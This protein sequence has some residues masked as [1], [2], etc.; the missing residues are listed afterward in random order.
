MTEPAELADGP[1]RLGGFELVSK[2]AEGGMGAVYRA[3]QLSLD[4]TV[5]VK[6]LPER[7]A[8]NQQFVA[9]FLREARLAARFSHPNVVG[10]VDA[11]E[12]D[13]VHYFA[14]EY[15]E[16]ESLGDLLK[17]EGALPEPRAIEIA[18]QIARALECAHKHGM[19]HRDVKPDNVLMDEEGTAK[20][21]DLGLARRVYDES[22]Q[23]TQ[24]GSAMGSPHYIAP[25][26]AMGESDIDIRADIYALGATFYQLVTG[27]TPF[28]GPTASVIMTKHLS[29]TPEPANVVLP[30]VSEETTRVIMKMMAKDRNRRYQTPAELIADLERLS[31]GEAVACPPADEQTAADAEATFLMSASDL[32]TGGKSSPVRR[33]PAEPADVRP[34]GRRGLVLAGVLLVAL[35]AAAAATAFVL[36][37]RKPG[38]EGDAIARMIGRARSLLDEEK[39]DEARGV[40]DAVF[41]GGVSGPQAE[42]AKELLSRLE[43][44]LREREAAREAELREKGAAEGLAAVKGL[45]AGGRPAEALARAR[46]GAEKYPEKRAAFEEL[47]S[48]ADM[49]LEEERH[50]K[51]IEKAFA[52]E[53]AK[54]DALMARKAYAE[55]AE[56]FSKALEI[57]DDPGVR[58]GRTEALSLAAKTR[59]ENAEASGDQGAAIASYE[60][61]IAIRPDADLAGVLVLR[62]VGAAPTGSPTGGVAYV[63]GEAVGDGFVVYSGL[64]TDPVPGDRSSWTDT[65]LLNGSEYHYA[66]FA[67][68]ASLNCAAGVLGSATPGAA[69]GGGSCAAGVYGSPVGI[70]ALLFVLLAVRRRG[71]ALVSARAEGTAE[72]AYSFFSRSVA[73]HGASRDASR[74]GATPMRSSGG[75]K[76]NTVLPFTVRA[77]H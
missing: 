4:R 37:S 36:G 61:A 56:A 40:L 48:R 76:D 38:G 60:K 65:G 30:S 42:E 49:L 70:L 11:G 20:F 57:R 19:V 74:C 66:V 12:A 33:G 31:R 6:I 58:A 28:T 52:A 51:E 34:G 46:A 45:L 22:T 73:R 53:G 35:I 2:I 27:A 54:A 71:A 5:A 10:A 15:V 26:Q 55:A 32:A 41:A 75:S 21:V 43:S 7:L 69:T 62:R 29:A 44:A 13:G 9:R 17:R 50:A 47:A 3:K 1:R 77:A 23:L 14:M 67:Y 59:G 68:D 25:E 64:G 8:K 16:G 72:D 63:V 39:L 24:A 18:M